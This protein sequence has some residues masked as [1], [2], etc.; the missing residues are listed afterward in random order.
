MIT[1]GNHI[2]KV[3]TVSNRFSHFWDSDCSDSN[4]GWYLDTIGS[5]ATYTFTMYNRDR[6]ITAYYKTLTRIT[7]TNGNPKT[8]EYNGTYIK[9]RLLD[10]I[11]NPIIQGPKNYH[12][13]CED[14][15]SI[16]NFDVDKNV[17]LEY[18][19]DGVN[20]NYLGTATADD[21]GYWLYPWNRVPRTA[22]L[23]ANYTPTNW[24]YYG[25]GVIVNYIPCSGDVDGNRIVN[26]IDLVKL[27]FAYDSKS[28]DSRW[29]PDA[30]FNKDNNV[31]L[32]DLVNL[33]SH[34]GWNYDSY[35]NFMGYS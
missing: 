25:T 8:F 22:K 6:V 15:G 20:W 12:P 16:H 31:N 1:P 18:S 26:L 27:A 35:C 5:T 29:N 17:I 21:Y 4:T 11:N 19:V 34:Y 3:D 14:P 24:F 28:G 10:E 13:V 2:L 23:S 30:D 32:Q 9:G 7:D 33:A